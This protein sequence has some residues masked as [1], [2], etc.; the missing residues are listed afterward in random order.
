MRFI[1]L[2]LSV[3]FI[4]SNIHAQRIQH[5][6]KGN[7]FYKQKDYVNA[8]G[9]YEK[10]WN[11]T[12]G[13]KLL[14]VDAKMN[15]ANCYRIM[16]N[17]FKAN[18]L[19]G[20]VMDYAEDRLSIYLEY[21]KVLMALGRYDDAIRQFELYAQ[22]DEASTEPAK[23]IQQCKDI[24][25]IEPLFAQVDITA[26]DAVNDIET[27]QIGITYYGD[28]VVFASDEMG[29]ETGDM[30]EVGYLNMR[31]SGVDATG[32]LKKS[33]RFSHSLNGFTRHDGPAAF[34][35][36]GIQIFYSQSVKTRDGKSVLQIWSAFFKNQHWSEPTP[37]P[38]MI[39]GKNYTHPTL[40]PDG[41]T[42]YFAS[43][44][45]GSHGGLD[46]WSSHYENGQ[47]TYPKNLGTDINTEQDDAW[48]FLHPDGDLYF[49]SKGHP[50]FGG[51]D[52]FRTRPL[53][54]GVDWL[55]I[56][57]LGQPFNSSF[58]DVS[59]IMSDD[60]TSGFLSSN[61]SKSYDI[62]RYKLPNEEPQSLPS[63]IAPRKSTGLSEISHDAILDAPFPEQSGDMTDAEYI[64][65]LQTLAE[66]G[67]LTL[68]T[69][70][71]SNPE[72]ITEGPT[73]TVTNPEDDLNKT[74]GTEHETVVNPA[75]NTVEDT[76]EIILEVVLKIMDVDNSRPLSDATIV[77]RNKFTQKETSLSVNDRGEVTV[78]LDKDQKYE[79]VGE[80]TG[81]APSSI[82]VSTMGVTESD[83][84]QAN[85]PMQKA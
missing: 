29:E 18:E 79:L 35:R 21:G 85:M 5:L 34:T 27:R 49:S 53:G 14:G 58:S 63:D 82:P 46:I 56:E 45:K 75:L 59:F 33:D 83:R 22:N 20:E 62:F 84:V 71:E 28:A 8:V 69:G 42:L 47:W 80:C 48:P 74:M 41:H 7:S 11:S 9:E 44:M 57:N 36:D 30:R 43:D 51:Y 54:N 73:T 4:A 25:N 32:N 65:H 72:A 17:P 6:K 13:A 38:F 64:E 26:Q 31:A 23:L 68:P 78:R 24:E 77:V 50:G 76:D 60:Q 39:V 3:F 12:A 52:I 66:E 2:V 19:Y 81:Y 40:S 70:E 61:R 67:K 37:M 16:D 1:I 55:P 10:L 15:L